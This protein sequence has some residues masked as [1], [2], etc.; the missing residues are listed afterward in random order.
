MSTQVP[1]WAWQNVS[2]LY[3]SL[4]ICLINHPHQT[5]ARC[6]TMA[7]QTLKTSW[8]SKFSQPLTFDLK[9]LSH[10][11]QFSKLNLPPLPAKIFWWEKLWFLSC[12][13]PLG[14]VTCLKCTAVRYHIFKPSVTPIRETY[15]NISGILWTIELS[16]W[17]IFP[18]GS[19]CW[20]LWSRTQGCVHAVWSPTWVWIPESP[21]ISEM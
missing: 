4:A 15:I 21:S 17:R 7:T 20:K 8:Q 3:S 16:T 9:C 5:R 12:S 13:A 18:D 2:F 11:A 14:L 10:P 19:L 1:W 6:W